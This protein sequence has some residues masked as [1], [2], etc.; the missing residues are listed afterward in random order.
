MEQGAREGRVVGAVAVPQVDRG[1]VGRAAGQ[2]A[3]ALEA[4]AGADRDDGRADVVEQDPQGGIV[5]AG[6]PE[7]AVGLQQPGGRDRAVGGH[8]RAAAVGEGD[9]RAVG[10]IAVG[11]HDRRRRRRVLTGV[12]AHRRQLGARRQVAGTDAP[13][14]LG[15]DLDVTG[16]GSG[17]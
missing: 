1:A 5:A 3:Q 8:P 6:E 9:H 16:H 13:G 4:A 2:R 11:T 7:H 12:R 10:E 14:D 17:P 15:A